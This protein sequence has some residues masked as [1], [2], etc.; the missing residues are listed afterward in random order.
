MA[1]AFYS[2]EKLFSTMGTSVALFLGLDP[3]FGPHLAPLRDSPQN[4]LLAYGNREIADMLTGKFMA[5]VT[6]F[7]AFLPG[8]GLD[9]A[10]GAVGKH[11]AG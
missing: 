10:G 1:A 11:L 5:L 9:R 7:I 2:P 8:A 6:P 3:F 4:D